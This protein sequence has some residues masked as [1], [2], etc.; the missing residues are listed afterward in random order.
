M[1]TVQNISNDII[2]TITKIFINDEKGISLEFVDQ[3]MYCKAEG[4]YTRIFLSN[5]KTI[6]KTKSLK[7]IDAHLKKN[8]CFFRIH[9]SYLVNTNYIHHFTNHNENKIILHN[10]TELPVA[11][12]KIHLLCTFL[13]KQKNIICL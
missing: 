5:G 1:K 3:I 8:P 13:K 4:S 6:L 2:K 12:R 10:Q 11:V 9:K 7:H